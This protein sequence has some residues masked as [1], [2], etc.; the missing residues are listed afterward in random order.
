MYQ[1]R[2]Q[3]HLL[4]GPHVGEDPGNKVVYVPSCK[5][6]MCLPTCK[7]LTPFICIRLLLWKLH[8]FLKLPMI[9]PEVEME[10]S[11]DCTIKSE[12]LH[13]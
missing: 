12:I 13:I 7:L 1:P 4:L 8:F 3:G 10:I 5:F 2:S 9:F 6:L 11:R